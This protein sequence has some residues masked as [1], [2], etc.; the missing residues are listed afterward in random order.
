MAKRLNMTPMSPAQI[1]NLRMRLRHD[2]KGF[3]ALLGAS[4]ATIR[5]WEKGRVTPKGPNL[6][7]LRLLEAGLATGAF[8]AGPG[9]MKVGPENET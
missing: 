1:L 8:V 5:N 9:E 3:A 6:A 4:V 7:A 2:R